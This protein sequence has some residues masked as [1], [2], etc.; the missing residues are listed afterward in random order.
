DV[1]IVLVEVDVP[2]RRR[3]A[4]LDLGMALAKP[5]EP[6]DQPAHGEGRHGG[7]SEAPS[8]VTPEH[9]CRAADDLVERGRDRAEVRASPIGERDAATATRD[10]LHAE[11]VLERAQLMADRRRRDA[12]LSGR[13]RDRTGTDHA[14]EGA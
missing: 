7:D 12:Q 5:P 9:R 2:V 6:R 4:Y 11:I 1:D 13:G 8:L 3:D 10:E 14:F